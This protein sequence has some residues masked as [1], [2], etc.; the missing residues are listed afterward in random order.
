VLEADSDIDVVAECQDGSELVRLVRRTAADLVVLDAHLLG[1]RGRDALLR[2]SM[3]S[4]PAVVLV[5]ARAGF[6]PLAFDAGAVDFVLKP[7]RRTRLQRAILR[8]KDIIRMRRPDTTSVK[9]ARVAAPPM[10]RFA[11]RSGS[12]ISL[13]RAIDLEW[14]E[15]AADYVRL[16]WNGRG[17]LL[18]CTMDVMERRLDPAQFVR[19]HR[20]TIVN[21]DAVVEF[22]RQKPED[23]VVVLRSGTVRSVSYR[24][25]DNV[26]SQFAIHL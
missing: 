3:G 25:R 13:V 10:Q 14:V 6:A 12:R 18:R 22:R 17:L 1:S 20:S 15:A 16:H 4:K 11:V 19:V 26:A 5:T 23:C 24:G 8:A 9:A 2:L 21:I 7:Y